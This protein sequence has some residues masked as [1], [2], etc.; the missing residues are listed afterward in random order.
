MGDRDEEGKLTR[1]A[2]L[3][4]AAAG[5]VL[6][7]VSPVWASASRP[8]DPERSSE[9]PAADYLDVNLA[10][11]LIPREDYRPFPRAEDRGEWEGLPGEVREAVVERGERHLG[12]EWP[13]LPATLFMEFGRTGNRSGYERAWFARNGALGALVLAECVEGKGRF[14]DDIINGVWSMCEE[15]SWIWPAHKGMYAQDDLLPDFSEH[16]IDLGVS[17]R[18]ALLAWTH[19]L[20]GGALDGVSRHV[21]RRIA[22]EVGRRVLDPYLARDDFWW[23]ALGEGVRHVNNWNPWCN[24]NCLAAFLL[25]EGDGERR[26]RGVAKVMRSL[27]RFLEGYPAD[28]GCD[29]GPGY[30]TQAGASLFECLELLDGASGGR[31]RVWDRPLIRD[32]GLY[33]LRVHISDAYFINFADA[34]PT[35]GLPADLVYRY[36]QRVGEPDLAAF[37]AAAYR[38][39]PGQLTE[40]GGS[41][42]RV[43]PGLFDA[44]A[45]EAAEARVPY[46]RD[47]WLGAIQVM[48]ARE[49]GGTDRG[50]YV[51]AKGG[52]NG[53]SH[54]HNDVGQFIVYCDGRPAII[55]PGVE[56]YTA[57]TFSD[58]RYEIWTMQSAYHNL[59]TVNGVQQHEGE[60]YRAADVSHRAD[61]RAAELLM[62][63]AGAYPEEAGIASW[64]RT[65]R[66]VREPKGYVEVEEDFWLRAASDRIT[67]TLMTPCKPRREGPGAFALPV[68]G[69][70]ALAVHFDGRG[71]EASVEE[72]P[73]SGSSLRSEWGDFLYR[74]L[75]RPKAAAKR[76]RWTVRMAAA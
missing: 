22:E 11:A 15:T 41:I 20:I 55:D 31:I 57:K 9:M 64:R 46:L 62:D 39:W 33:I 58:E 47:V 3:K 49:Q 14:V 23:M 27:N 63:I 35:V 19:Y 1:R 52:H 70:R 32:M 59:P 16:I 30:W 4:A 8:T 6:G 18:A 51:G 24:S 68:E 25:L 38:R 54:N 73:L 76:G 69:A 53:E 72:M 50:L 66:L 5:C 28:G 21:G 37:G 42:M 45:L 26:R 65:I 74:I 34:H 61:D 36:G 10:E 2:F 40:T 12:Y 75:L 13:R 56:T 67:L 43:L 7:A 17:E 44:R 29:E 60:E 71:L 48:A